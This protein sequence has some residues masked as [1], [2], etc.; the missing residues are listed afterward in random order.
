MI[1]DFFECLM[2]G[3]FDFLDGLFGI[4]PQMPFDGAQIG[5]WLGLSELSTV[6]G[7]VNFFLP[8]DVASSIVA[9]WSAAVMAYVGIKLAMKYTGEIV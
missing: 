6:L 9:V 8:L 3:V 4:L 5:Q 7:W 1:A 2:N